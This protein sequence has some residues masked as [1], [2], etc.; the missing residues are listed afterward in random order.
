MVTEAK[1][2]SVSM[3]NKNEL[4]RGFFDYKFR[5][6]AQLLWCK[7]DFLESQMQMQIKNVAAKCTQI[8]N[9]IQCRLCGEFPIPKNR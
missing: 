2:E 8:V 5:I 7:Y 3:K 4:H 6:R 9:C 1:K